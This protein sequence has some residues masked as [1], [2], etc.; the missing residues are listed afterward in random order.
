MTSRTSK[1]PATKRKSPA[2]KAREAR[3]RAARDKATQE[4]PATPTPDT[5]VDTP[6]NADAAM[7]FGELAEGYLKAL[8]TA[9]KSRGCVFSYSIDIGLAVRHFGEKAK[10]A[11][12]TEQKII[13]FFE[14]DLVT[15]TRTG[16]PKAKPTID[17]TRRVLRQALVW[18]AEQ[19]IIDA[20]PIPAK[21]AR[22]Q[23][24]TATT[25]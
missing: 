24:R 21:Y 20:A 17:K 3:A 16:K 1:A 4:P 22:R 2:Q 9:G 8:E 6:S 19:K 12:L 14:S 5:A 15:K 18:A 13:K 25:T 10:V 11:T 7:T 23:K